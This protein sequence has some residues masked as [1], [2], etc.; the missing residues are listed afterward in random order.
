MVGHAPPT[1]HHVT[2]A[3]LTT[4]S[5]GLY[6][7]MQ[8]PYAVEDLFAPTSQVGGGAR[9]VVF[10]DGRGRAASQLCL[11]VDTRVQEVLLAGLSGLDGAEVHMR[12]RQALGPSPERQVN[13]LVAACQEVH[14]LF[15]RLRC[16]G[17]LHEVT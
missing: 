1:S 16:S 3:P 13:G 12:L 2:D 8:N 5:L 9:H 15:V 4:Q 14:S 10:H 17:T 11:R 6:A 7:F